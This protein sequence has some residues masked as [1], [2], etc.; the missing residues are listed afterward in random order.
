MTAEF[1]AVVL[2][3]F[4]LWIESKTGKRTPRRSVQRSFVPRKRA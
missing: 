2:R 3:W 4:E 1:Q